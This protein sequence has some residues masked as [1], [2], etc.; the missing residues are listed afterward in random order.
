MIRGRVLRTLSAL[1]L[2]FVVG[3][4]WLSSTDSAMGFVD[5]D[6]VSVTYDTLALIDVGDTLGTPGTSVPVSLYLQNLSDSIQ[7]FTVSITLSNPDLMAFVSQT[8]IDTC[9]PCLD[10]ACTQLDTVQCTIE[11]VP[12]TTQNTLIQNWD[13]AQAR[14]FGG[15][16]ILVS[17][18]ADVDFDQSP[19]PI[20]PFTNG[21]L[22]KVIAQVNC[23]IPD[24]LSDRVV[25]LDINPPQTFLTNPKGRTIPSYTILDADTTISGPDT[26]VHL[27]L[28]RTALK[29]QNGS[30]TVPFTLKGDLNKDGVYNVQDVVGL[31]NVAFRGAQEPCPPG[32]ADLN[33]DGVVSIVDVVLLVNHVFRGGPQPFC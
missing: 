19:L 29:Y 2:V 9:Y 18:I 32:I 8:V 14:T 21:V 20:L 6:T 4:A 22:I 13:H 26:T 23:N 25:L 17:G 28:Y 30:I 24:T 12:S 10:S 31:V 7:G 11:V 27:W 33:C 15:T 5:Y 1:M 3:L 16:N